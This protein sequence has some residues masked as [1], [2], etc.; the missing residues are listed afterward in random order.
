MPD[1]D[2]YKGTGDMVLSLPMAI[3]ELGIALWLLLRGGKWKA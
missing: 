1:Y 2:E 3:G